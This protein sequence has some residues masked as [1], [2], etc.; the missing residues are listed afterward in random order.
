MGKALSQVDRG[1]AEQ[2]Q[3]LR[4]LAF[5]N[6]FIFHGESWNFFGYPVHNSAR[7]AVS[8]FF[9][10]SGLVTGYNGFGREVKLTCREIGRHMAKKVRKIYP[11][12]LLSILIPLLHSG[13]P[14]L[15][16]EGDWAALSQELTLLARTLLLIQSWFQ[17][18]YFH[19]NGVAW[20]LS[21]LL[22]LNL[23]DLPGICLLNRGWK[24]KKRYLLFGGAA[25][26]ILMLTM[27]HCGLT[28]SLSRTYWHYIFP[29]ARLGEYLVGMILGFAARPFVQ[30]IPQSKS[31]RWLFTALEV[32]ALG[33]WWL[34][35]HTNGPYWLRSSVYWMLPNLVLLGI[36]T[37]GKGA[38]SD[39]FRSKRLVWLGD[40]S[41]ECYLFHGMIITRYEINHGW[42]IASTIDQAV[43]FFF[44]LALT[45]L[46]AAVLH[47]GKKSS[48]PLPNPPFSSTLS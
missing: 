42:A 16:A 13:L 23:F 21:T 10:L 44:C 22:F 27:L 41:F 38:V 14:E 40:I 20:F 47:Q 8:F 30:R 33:L 29:P 7:F 15:I 45:L 17:E 24:E 46:A 18:G 39:V 19:L 6:V 25:F 36:F 37:L 9:C 1:R 4:F 43:A 2:L 28:R 5:M 12:Y 35:L 3:F 32:G 48:K 31:N 34:F 26:C 11:L